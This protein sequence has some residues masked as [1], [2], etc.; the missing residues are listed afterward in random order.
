MTGDHELQ[1]GWGV[2]LFGLRATD[3]SCPEAHVLLLPDAASRYHFHSESARS[4]RPWAHARKHPKVLVG[5]VSES[6]TIR[7]DEYMLH[8]VPK[9]FHKTKLNFQLQALLYFHIF[10]RF[11][12]RCVFIGIQ[13]SQ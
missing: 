8:T 12:I 4:R 6:E 9:Q 13:K 3:R 11:K 2:V 1:A 5:G 7:D 10:S